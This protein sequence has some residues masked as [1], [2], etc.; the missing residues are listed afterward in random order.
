[1]HIKLLERPSRN[2]SLVVKQIIDIARELT[3]DWFT[4]DVPEWIENDLLFQDVICLEAGDQI[5]S[6][7]IFSSIEGVLNITLMGTEPA[8]RNHGYG[9][10]MMEVLFEYAKTR[11]FR[12]IELLTVPPEKRSSYH[13]TVAFYSKHGFV[14]VKEYPELWDTGAAKFTKFL[15]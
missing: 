2:N 13:S 3:E 14:R 8:Y 1:M 6:F 15:E 5:R 9:S 11:G 10:K 4:E 12:K 7:I